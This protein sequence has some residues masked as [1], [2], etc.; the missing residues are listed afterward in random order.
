MTSK[1]GSN[2]LEKQPLFS[3][4]ECQQKASPVRGGVSLGFLTVCGFC[5]V[6]KTV[7]NSLCREI[8]D[9][10]TEDPEWCGQLIWGGGGRL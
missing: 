10:K 7:L 5:F 2:F 3:S 1:H 6:S 9:M 4:Q 8:A